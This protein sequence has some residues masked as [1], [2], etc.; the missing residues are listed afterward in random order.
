M[1]N[2]FADFADLFE[3][4][5][6][7]RVS[8]PVESV[9]TTKENFTITLEVP[10]FA[11]SEIDV[12]VK[13]RALNIFADH[14]GVGKRL[15]KS[16]TRSWSLPIDVAVDQITSTLKLGVLTVVVPRKAPP[17]PTKVQVKVLGQ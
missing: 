7:F 17:A 13:G 5:H 6:N 10:G 14:K 8:E 11:E 12:H 3:V 9:E 4:V 1:I 16:V 2:P 15:T